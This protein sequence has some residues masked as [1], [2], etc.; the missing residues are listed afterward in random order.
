MSGV[1]LPQVMS[2]QPPASRLPPPASLPHS[3]VRL[4]VQRQLLNARGPGPPFHA[5]P[6]VRPMRT[7][8]ALRGC[9]DRAAENRKQAK[10]SGFAGVTPESRAD[11]PNLPG[12]PDGL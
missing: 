12:A 3:R 11:F 7:P 10:I 9:P 6:L 5:M 1:A 2:H 4:G 8:S